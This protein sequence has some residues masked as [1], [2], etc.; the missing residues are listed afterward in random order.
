MD[1]KYLSKCQFNSLEQYNELPDVAVTLKLVEY[2]EEH[3]YSDIRYDHL[4]TC[5]PVIRLSTRKNVHVADF[6]S[7][8]D[9]DDWLITN[10]GVIKMTELG[11]LES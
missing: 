1:A 4:Q 10:Y 3:H 5:I 11:L 8:Q 9:L 6:Q 2:I 7:T